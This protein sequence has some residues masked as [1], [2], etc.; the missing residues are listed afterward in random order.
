MNDTIINGKKVSIPE[1][2]LFADKSDTGNFAAMGEA[3][4]NEEG[5][6]YCQPDPPCDTATHK[7]S[8]WERVGSKWGRRLIEKTPEEIS[9]H[10]I[11]LRGDITSEIN[12]IARHYLDQVSQDYSQTEAIE[13]ANDRAQYRA[14]N[15]GHFAM[16]AG[17]YMT[18]QQY[19]DNKFKPKIEAGSYFSEQIK[20]IRTDLDYELAITADGDLL[21][22]DYQS[23]WDGVGDFVTPDTSDIPTTWWQSLF[24]A[25]KWWENN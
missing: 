24:S 16:R 19:V 11:D 6:F 25:I 5:F 8:E 20:G 10:Y 14:G 13:W 17:R 22:F 7:L 15:I 3:V 23:R 2:H 4:H 21:T 1:Y 12:R 18:A 9:Q